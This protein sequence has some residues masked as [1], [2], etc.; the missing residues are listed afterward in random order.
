MGLA[1][2]S[3]LLAQ[4]SR[5]IFSSMSH[6]EAGREAAFERKIEA[7]RRESAR[8]HDMHE[9]ALAADEVQGEK[10]VK[11]LDARRLPAVFDSR[12]GEAQQTAAAKQAAAHEHNLQARISRYEQLDS[13]AH[14]KLETHL[15]AENAKS[16][17]REANI[18]AHA[19]KQAAASVLKPTEQVQEQEDAV[20]Y[21]DAREH[22]FEASVSKY[23][24]ASRHSVE[25]YEA[26]VAA[27]EKAHAPQMHTLVQHALAHGEEAS[28]GENRDE[29]SSS[30]ARL[31]SKVAAA[32]SKETEVRRLKMLEKNAVGAGTRDP[33]LGG[34]SGEQK[35][36]KAEEQR[37][38]ARQ[39]DFKKRV[40]E[41][42]QKAA[43]EH[44]LRQK[45][46]HDALHKMQM[47]AAARYASEKVKR[48]E[49]KKKRE[50]RQAVQ[51][52][53]ASI[54]PAEWV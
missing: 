20:K 1:D 32:E 9:H 17:A 25:K 3:R 49:W 4:D 13:A 29:K 10:R 45:A 37:E 46:A 30:T 53:L 19:E 40:E 41:E 18:A 33:M 54:R 14:R 39:L 38:V 34:V 8:E 7:L 23:R 16:L 2:A 24:K 31:S 28:R 52:V 48:A 51:K 12:D 27:D 36:F 50:E 35:A 47:E 26:A 43:A 5:K 22:S 6:Y 44:R 15:H 42:S 21:A 11:A